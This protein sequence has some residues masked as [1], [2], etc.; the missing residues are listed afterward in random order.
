MTLNY[1]TEFFALK[2]LKTL[3]R[4]SGQPIKKQST[5]FPLGPS[6]ILDKIQPLLLMELAPGVRQQHGYNLMY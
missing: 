5:Y 3:L 2:C 4:L 1:Y 6:H